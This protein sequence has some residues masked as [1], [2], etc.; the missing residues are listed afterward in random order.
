MLPGSPVVVKALLKHIHKDLVR[1][2]AL[3]EGCTPI[4]HLKPVMHHFVHYASKTKKFAILTILWMMGFER[5]NKYLKNHVRNAHHPNINLA[6]TT[7]QTDTANFFT[8]LEED[9]Y[10]LRSDLY[11]RCTSYPFTPPLLPLHI[12]TEPPPAQSTDAF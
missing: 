6:K 7:S 12:S 11:H 10:E 1:G 3:F 2:L 8:L 4:D 9:K 5:Y